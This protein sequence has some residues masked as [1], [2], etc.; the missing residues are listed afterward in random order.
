MNSKV[1]YSEAARQN[2]EL[3]ESHPAHC[4]CAQ[5]IADFAAAYSDPQCPACGDEGNS[6][7]SLGKREH[8][9]CRAC[10]ID[11]SHEG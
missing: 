7:G 11:F 4:A 6:L 3:R 9:R 2:A 5:C 1:R 8:F 10:G